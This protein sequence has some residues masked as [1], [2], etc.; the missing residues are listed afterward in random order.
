MEHLLN[1]CT[2]E[3]Q[4]EIV[5][6]LIEVGGQQNK[7]AALL[8]Y[9][10]QH[11]SQSL[12]RIKLRASRQG[13]A[14][15]AGLTHQTATGFTT[16]RVSTMYGDDGEIRAQWHIQEADKSASYEAALS[17]IESFEWSPAPKI[18]HSGVSI[19]ELCT[20]YTLTDYHIGMYAHR[21]IGGDDWDSK[22]AANTG[23]KAL[24]QM[25]SGSPDSALGILNLQGDF[26]HY[27]S[28]D[29]LTPTSKH[30]VDADSRFEQLVDVALKLVMTMIEMLLEKHKE[31]KVIVCEGNHDIVSSLWLRKLIKAVYRDNKRMSVDDTS[32][33]YYAHLHGSVLLGF[34]HGHKKKNKDL[35]SLFASEPR[36]RELW[37]KSKVTYIHTGHYHHQE[38]DIKE[39]LGAIVERHPTLAARDSYAARGGWTSWR[40]AHAITYHSD[41]GEQ[42]R[43]TV[44][45][46]GATGAVA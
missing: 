21:D 42:M 9:S 24:S 35:P 41:H 17:A 33:P 20:L 25:I 23:I 44:T 38:Q 43:V 12:Q 7:V 8:G 13:V 16:K 45:P 1:Y 3:K 11:I 6:A 29:P 37:G 19:K 36:Y 30:L 14:P 18:K 15:E 2:N 31:V 5:K 32:F 27:D 26:F 28:L 22:I 4:K 10:Q 34:H 39:D 46:I 40:A